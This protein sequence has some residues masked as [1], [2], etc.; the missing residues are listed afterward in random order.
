MVRQAGT[1]LTLAT[2]LD[3]PPED[4]LILTVNNRLS[5]TVT[6]LYA[7]KRE[8]ATSVLPAILPWRS[9][10][11]QCAFDLSFS[12]MQPGDPVHVLDPAVSRL[13]W[14]EV[15][16]RRDE[17]DG[18]RGLID[19]EQLA[20]LA[21]QADELVLHWDVQV[22]AAWSTPEY[23]QFVQWQQAY[24]DRLR[25]LIAID[26]TRLALSMQ[27]WIRQGRIALAKNVVFAGFT[28]RSPVLSRLIAAI[29]GQGR[30]VYELTAVSQDQNHPPRQIRSE[31]DAGQWHLAINWARQALD[32]HPRGRFAIVVPDLQ[33]KADQVRRLL[34]R[35][36]TPDHAFNV[37]VAPALLD[38]PPARAMFAWLRVTGGF[39]SRGVVPV[40]VAGHALLA[41]LCAGDLAE[42]GERAM[43]D[44]RWRR[45][46]AMNVGLDDW[47]RELEGLA[48]LGPAWNAVYHQWQ[49]FDASRTRRWDDWI[50]VFRRSLS[51]LG[52]PGDHARTSTGFQAVQAL[53]ALFVK[54]AG[55]DDF[56]EPVSWQ[57]ALS[58]L[59]S[60][61][62]QTA[63]QPQRDRSARLDVLGLLESEAGQ[64]DGVW[65]MDMID[66][67]LPAAVSPNPL[68]P[69]Q[70]LSQA[71][72]PR[73]TAQREYEWAQ[74]M[75][76]S[77]CNV[78]P[79]VT[80]SWPARDEQQALRPSPFLVALDSAENV[81]D[82]V[83]PDPEHP[84][85]LE[86]WEDGPCPALNP[87][88]L[89]H[90]GV[91]VL[92]LQSRNPM[93]AFVRHRL[94]TRGLEPY[95]DTPLRS[96]R[97]E[98]LHAVMRAIWEKLRTRDNLR[99]Q[100]ETVDFS[101]WIDQTVSSLAG[102]MLADWPAALIP[103]ECA[104][105]IELVH[106]WL[107]VESDRPAFEV[108][109]MESPY[110]LK[111]GMLDIKVVID[112]IDKASPDFEREQTGEVQTDSEPGWALLDYKTGMSRATP[113]K[114]WARE[115]P[116]D[117][118]M[119]AYV[120]ALRLAKGHWPVAIVW[121]QLHP[122]R[123]EFGGVAMRD[124][125]F[126]QKVETE[127]GKKQQAQPLTAPLWE[128]VLQEWDDKL[129]SL[130]HEFQNGQAS[131][132]SQ[133]ENDLKYCDIRHILRLHEES[134][135]D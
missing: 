37:A 41:G 116:I 119:L 103:L 131:N 8:S 99:A 113:F 111:I 97:G 31:D 28:Q 24:E 18:M 48:Q 67:V 4:T 59:E 71:E 112:R 7:R 114:D 21:D 82:A 118:Q 50:A 134:G 87:D 74:T 16:S 135:D 68:L 89:I 88:E 78:A 53:D 13:L 33:A 73:S 69:R 130:A 72:A 23:E 45:A 20:T 117:I 115:R 39:R 43:I 121:A 42:R 55:F 84:I 108:V 15:I 80:M 35:A 29:I 14:R 75:F 94:N 70:A 60:L 6:S 120:R 79:S 46:G 65:V 129:E 76:E 128:Q 106:K 127:V 90:G 110:H 133:S 126:A 51:M 52:F 93:W 22:D 44:A 86:T 25:A 92:D 105:T 123:L 85:A 63:F 66:S 11:S 122:R 57:Q 1:P 30:A 104:R 77:L 125:G 56:F 5:R 12:E 17:Q 10:M 19:V 32:T 38:W 2:L 64:W 124:Y 26:R 83:A 107:E 49:D 102:L 132:V 81:S 3:L 61:A 54:V 62:R 96:Q 101:W 27:G 47:L 100:R 36:L 34:A 91:S 40:E 98:F 58:R 109:E 9:W 95:A